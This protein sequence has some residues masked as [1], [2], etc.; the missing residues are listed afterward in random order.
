MPDNNPPELTFKAYFDTSVKKVANL[1]GGGIAWLGS[2]YWIRFETNSD[3]ALKD[4]GD[5]QRLKEVPVQ[6]VLFFLGKFPN[7]KSVL[8]DKTNLV[9]FFNPG[10]RKSPSSNGTWFLYNKASHTYFFRYWYIT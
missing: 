1:Q 9:C 4:Q 2:E 3:I 10:K 6:A 7:D 8:E 5:Y